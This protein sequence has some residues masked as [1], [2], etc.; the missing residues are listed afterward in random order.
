MRFS[1]CA[2]REACTDEGTHCR[3]CGRPH[4][5][6]ARTRELTTLLSDFLIETGYENPEEFLDYVR[7][8]ALKKLKA[9]TP[10]PGS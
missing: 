8:K 2:S 1:P 9:A 6:I 3:G 10:D 4:T 5:H 7:N